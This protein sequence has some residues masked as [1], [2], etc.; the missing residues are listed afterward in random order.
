MANN[1]IDPISMMLLHAIK[2]MESLISRK[3]SVTFKLTDKNLSQIPDPFVQQYAK[4][5]LE[6]SQVCAGITESSILLPQDKERLLATYRKFLKS[7][8]IE[9]MEKQWSATKNTMVNDSQHYS[10]PAAK[11]DEMTDAIDYIIREIESLVSK[12]LSK[13]FKLTSTSVSE[14]LDTNVKKF[15]SEAIMLQTALM[16]LNLK[17]MQSEDAQGLTALFQTMMKEF[18]PKALEQGWEAKVVVA[19]QFDKDFDDQK[20]ET[21]GL[22][23]KKLEAVEEDDPFA[24]FSD[25]EEPKDNRGIIKERKDSGYETDSPNTIKPGRH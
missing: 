25:D 22:Q 16:N 17:K 3:L 7:F 15:A 5:L 10:I 21:R 24:D 8:D 23:L 6:F 19:E 11:L 1:F 9:K 12:K 2:E 13:N 4:E 18:N 14:I 20:I